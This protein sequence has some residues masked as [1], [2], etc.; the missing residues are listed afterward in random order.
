M[1]LRLD[2]LLSEQTKLYPFL[3]QI[4]KLGFVLFGGTAIALQLGHRQSVDFDFFHEQDI[5]DFQST[6]LNLEGLNAQHVLQNEPNSLCF[7]TKN[8][9]KLSFFGRIEWVQYA[10][11]FCSEDSILQLANLDSLLITKLKAICDRA[12]CKDYKD[13]IA[14]L[15]TESVDLLHSLHRVELFFGKA[16]PLGQILKGL[17]YFE[18]GDLK[19][20]TKKEKKFL[21]RA[22][23]KAG[24][25]LGKK[26]A[27]N[28]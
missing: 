24:R 27:I 7:Q 25:N 21:E 23:I 17:T 11:T 9:V 15:K 14:I 8:N 20:L 22:A 12:E 2:I 19:L 1:Q 5:S 28:V 26:K 3:Q 6:L 16:V 18:D 13:I 4:T 10:E